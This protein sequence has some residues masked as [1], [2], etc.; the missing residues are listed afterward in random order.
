MQKSQ[1]LLIAS[2]GCHQHQG[3][4]LRQSLVVLVPLKGIFWCYDLKKNLTVFYP[5][6]VKTSKEIGMFQSCYQGLRLKIKKY[7]KA[8]AHP[9]IEPSYKI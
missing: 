1:R 4:W 6:C 9:K 3:R 2:G 7:K 8:K 5:F